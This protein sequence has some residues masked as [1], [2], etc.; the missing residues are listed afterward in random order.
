MG[1]C[2]R[3]FVNRPIEIMST[4]KAS[5]CSRKCINNGEFV[6]SSVWC[7]VGCVCGV[8]GVC[9]VVCGCCGVVCVV[10]CVVV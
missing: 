10:W 1:E 6:G 9:S 5:E 3:K 2:E 4:E 7:V 8:V